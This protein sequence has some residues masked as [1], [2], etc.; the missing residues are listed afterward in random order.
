M[1]W[2]FGPSAGRWPPAI[3]T[4]GTWSHQLT[5]CLV[6][7]G[8]AEE[9]MDWNVL[10]PTSSTGESGANTLLPSTSGSS[11]T[12]T[13]RMGVLIRTVRASVTPSSQLCSGCGVLVADFHQW[14]T[15]ECGNNLD[16][17]HQT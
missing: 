11:Y 6:T 13:Q 10:A 4:C 14:F 3:P 1:M 15:Q 7:W 8:H 2:N 9:G 17:G 12:T 16:E 5:R